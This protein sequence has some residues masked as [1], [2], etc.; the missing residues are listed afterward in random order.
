M[1]CPS[2]DMSFLK[3]GR[4]R[5]APS[6]LQSAYGV[7][8]LPPRAGI[9][10][11]RVYRAHPKFRTTNTWHCPVLSFENNASLSEYPVLAGRGGIPLDVS[12]GANEGG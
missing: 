10:A 7:T 3:S 11:Y 2:V 1:H 9:W 8:V 4:E 12:D 5:N 6:R